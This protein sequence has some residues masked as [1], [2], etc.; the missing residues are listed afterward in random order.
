[1]LRI[2]VVDCCGPVVRLRV[3]G[4]L[5]GRGVEE[6]RQSCEIHASSD[7]TRLVL[8]LGDVSFADEGGIKL[9]ECL[10]AN[11]VALANLGP[12]LSAQLREFVVSPVA[13]KGNPDSGTTP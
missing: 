8:D 3:E 9:L 4:R 11:N 13:R 10:R 12:F 2:T 1:M 5:A 7:D 6:L